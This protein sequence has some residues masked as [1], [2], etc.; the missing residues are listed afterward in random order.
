M[1]LIDQQRGVRIDFSRGKMRM[2]IEK[3]GRG[4]RTECTSRVD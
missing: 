3:T 2:E 1:R 4:M